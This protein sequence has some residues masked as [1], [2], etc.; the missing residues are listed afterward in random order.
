[1]VACVP[2]PSVSV[3][4][5]DGPCPVAPLVVRRDGEHHGI[6]EEGAGDC[7]AGRGGEQ[8]TH[9]DESDREGPE[10]TGGFGRLLPPIPGGLDLDP[11]DLAR[12]TPL[13]RPLGGVPGRGDVQRVR[14]AAGPEGACI[15][16]P[17]PS[18]ALSL[19]PPAACPRF[20]G[21]RAR[22][23]RDRSLPPAPLTSRPPP[24]LDAFFGRW[25][26]PCAARAGRRCRRRAR[27]PCS[28]HT[29]GR[30]PPWSNACRRSTA[31]WA[32]APSKV[33]WVEWL[34]SID[35]TTCAV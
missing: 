2:C 32:R 21:W 9:G 19:L 5:T 1:M 22:L 4:T 8:G 18:H 6:D 28:T 23:A 7:Q 33:E 14:D 31:S 34:R 29:R 13:P 16:P 26:T 15:G 27:K 20:A 35:V 12:K 10:R 3:F 30:R 11:S 25:R 24:R 17:L